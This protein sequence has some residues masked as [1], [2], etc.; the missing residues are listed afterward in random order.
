MHVSTCLVE[1]GGSFTIPPGVTAIARTEGSAPVCGFR[2]NFLGA[3]DKEALVAL[4]AK[5]EFLERTK[6][7]LSK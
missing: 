7:L 6:A 5:V 4:A 3:R 1:A 2:C